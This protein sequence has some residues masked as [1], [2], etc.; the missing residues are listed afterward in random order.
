M[1]NAILKTWKQ[2]YENKSTISNSYL[3]ENLLLFSYQNSDMLMLHFSASTEFTIEN[4]TSMQMRFTGHYK[5]HTN[6]T[7]R[8]ICTEA[9]ARGYE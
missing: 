7:N 3:P 1:T 4:D 2:C 9:E 5:E 6:E 8:Y